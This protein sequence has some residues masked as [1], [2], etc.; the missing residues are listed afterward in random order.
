MSKTVPSVVHTGSSNGVKVT[1][2]QNHNKT[3][4]N[5]NK[6]GICCSKR[7]EGNGGDV[8]AAVEGEAFERDGSVLGFGAAPFGSPLR[9][10]YEHAI[11]AVLFFP[12]VEFSRR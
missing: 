4:I 1:L 3:E 9:F 2:H 10:G 6:F 5:T 8:R 11:F 12:H 7:V